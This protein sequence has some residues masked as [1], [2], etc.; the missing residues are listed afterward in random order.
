LKK[1]TLHITNGSSL[2]NYLNDLDFKGVFFTWHEMLCEGPTSVDLTSDEFLTKRKLFFKSV[3][4]LEID[5]AK[6]NEE[7]SKLD[8][9]N[10]KYDEIVLW[11]EYDL[12]CHINL[13]AVLSLLEKLAI[14][15]PISLVSSGW[16]E[17]DT[18]LKALSQLNQE[19]LFKHYKNRQKLTPEDIELGSTLWKIYN[20]KD[21]NLFLPYITK[22]SNFR[23]LSN[24]LKAHIKR[25]PD[26]KTGLNDLEYNTLKL[27][28]KHEIKS[29]HQLLG[30]VLN[31]QGYYGYGDIQI[32]RML[33]LLAELYT[34]N[35]DGKYILTRKGHEALLGIHN[36][37]KEI[38]DTIDYGGVNSTNYM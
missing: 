8:G 17:N 30:Y 16:V 18:Q 15:L 10:T 29:E 5:E 7:F 36:F 38:G 2:T 37:A 25:F 4:N 1:D 33:S 3:Y 27:I 35:N 13:I 9:A 11:F 31:Y 6:F 23:Y 26:S 24:C 21:H 12:F 19:Q 34:S 20:G 22:K 32:K 14:S 28:E